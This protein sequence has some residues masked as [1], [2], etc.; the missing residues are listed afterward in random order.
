MEKAPD[1]DCLR[2]VI[3]FA[4]RRLMSCAPSEGFVVA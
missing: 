4:A 2:E 1:A 3:G